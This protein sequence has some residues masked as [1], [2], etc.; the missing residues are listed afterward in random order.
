M[1]PK[2]DAYDFFEDG[3]FGLRRLMPED[4]SQRHLDWL[5]DSEVTKFL[6]VR[7]SPPQSLDDLRAWVS[8]FDHETAYIWGVYDS[9][10]DLQLGTITLYDIDQ[11]NRRALVGFMVGDREYWGRNVM[12][13]TVPAVLDFAFNALA[14]NK[15][16]VMADIRNMGSIIVFKK[17]GFTK[18]GYF[19]NHIHDNGEW[20]D[21]VYFGLQKQEW[22]AHR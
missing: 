15:I 10:L 12:P 16:S 20:F 19:K 3:E 17:L 9:R 18:E 14:L 6:A 13:K 4:V 5:H 7:R 22:L 21:E 11:A 8:A 1:N 2:T